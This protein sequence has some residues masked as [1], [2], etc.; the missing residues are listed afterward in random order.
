MLPARLI[1]DIDAGTLIRS[2]L[3]A[4]VITLPYGIFKMRQVRAARITAGLDSHRTPGEPAPLDPRSLEAVIERIT[5]LAGVGGDLDLP[6]CCT[7][8][9]QPVTADV[10]EVL[11]RDALNRSNLREVG[12]RHSEDNATTTIILEPVPQDSGPQDSGPLEQ[13]DG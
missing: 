2:A 7:V 9:G 12:R 10:S 8:D 3:L 1:A 13:T 6:D 11:V 4:I 5:D